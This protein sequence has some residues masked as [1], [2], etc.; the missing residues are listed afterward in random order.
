M[1]SEGEWITVNGRHIMLG[2]GES[3]Q[4]AINRSI[5]KKN[6]ELKEKQIKQNKDQADKLNG[7]PAEKQLSDD[8]DKYIKDIY[9]DGY[10]P[11][12]ED[13]RFDYDK[14]NETV[15]EVNAAINNAIE[16]NLDSAF[17]SKQYLPKLEKQALKESNFTRLYAIRYLKHRGVFDNAIKTLSK[18]K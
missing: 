9:P 11:A 1:A 2:G 14:Y 5:A 18:N 10:E 15:K 3:V 8:V 16:R 4:D 17:I 13:K 6:E 12:E 7:K